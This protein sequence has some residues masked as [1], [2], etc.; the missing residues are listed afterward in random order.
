[1]KSIQ[2]ELYN[3]QSHEHTVFTLEPGLNFI[4][5][6]DNNVGKSTIFKALSLLFK[7]PRVSNRDLDEMLR[8]YTDKGYIACRW[9]DN[10]VILWIYRDGNRI[11]AFFEV[12]DNSG[13]S[14]VNVCPSNL[15]EAF[16]IILGDDGVPLNFNNADSVQL[17]VQDSIENDKVLSKA[18]ID[19]R[20]EAIKDNAD[21]LLKTV[22]SDLSR[23]EN[24]YKDSAQLLSSM[25]F[26][27]SSDIFHQEETLLE[28]MCRVSDT[29]PALSEIS[30]ESMK[31][32]EMSTVLTAIKVYN[33]IGSLKEEQSTVPAV[34][35]LQAMQT[36]IKYYEIL[37][38]LRDEEQ[39]PL[40]S[41]G[42]CSN[43][44]RAYEIVQQLEDISNRCNNL[45]RFEK[46]IAEMKEEQ[47]R[48]LDKLKSITRDVICP[49]KG[50]VFYSDEECVPRD[51]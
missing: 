19:F 25:S 44:F 6:D 3:I 29:L 42:V 38:N 47:L 43:M 40:L 50:R 18:L 23:V 5:A 10:L 20:V 7:M 21:N 32:E 34:P 26:N 22:S 36:A 35:D 14:R 46:N 33:I 48:L 39:V 45:S 9:E 24:K 12:R 17:V 4:L 28:A 30:L 15:R 1:M 8:A 49:I 51:N 41:T 11:N 13:S 31:S 27:E 2:L 16:D 37:S